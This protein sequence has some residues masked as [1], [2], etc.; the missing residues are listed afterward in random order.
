VRATPFEN[1]ES[2][3]ASDRDAAGTGT[4]RNRQKKWRQTYFAFANLS[5]KNSLA[6]P[7]TKTVPQTLKSFAK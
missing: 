7:R 6:F 2:P 1:L 5:A 3:S 4:G